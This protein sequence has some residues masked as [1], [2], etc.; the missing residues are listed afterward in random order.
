MWQPHE[1]DWLRMRPSPPQR[2]YLSAAIQPSALARE[3]GLEKLT[4]R[5]RAKILSRPKVL[6]WMRRSFAV[7]FVGLAGKLALA[8]RS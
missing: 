8:E 1:A 5:A 3:G 7:A 4:R 2:L 6:K